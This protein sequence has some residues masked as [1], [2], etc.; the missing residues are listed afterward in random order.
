MEQQLQIRE[1]LVEE[2][3]QKH[4]SGLYRTAYRYVRNEQD[5]L[6]IVQES[7]YKAMKH[8]HCLREPNY[9]VTWLYQIVRNEAVSFLRKNKID[10]VPLWEIDGEQEP[11][12]A[13]VDLH[14]A[15][16][17]LSL[18]EKTVV[19]LRFFEGL[20]FQQI[21]E[22]LQENINTVKSRLYRALQKLKAFLEEPYARTNERGVSL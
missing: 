13:D 12:Y 18:G 16:A 19:L 7:A 2:C 5:A 10:C 4:Y 17:Q 20:S 1:Q 15:M 3:L 22:M 11:R 9:A 14:R 6:D 21:A 8:C